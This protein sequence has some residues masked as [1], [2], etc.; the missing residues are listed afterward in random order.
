M[1]GI[2]NSHLYL[3]DIKKRSNIHAPACLFGIAHLI[4][5]ANPFKRLEDIILGFDS[6]MNGEDFVFHLYLIDR[7]N[8]YRQDQ[9]YQV[10]DQVIHNTLPMLSIHQASIK[11]NNRFVVVTREQDAA[12]LTSFN[13]DPIIIH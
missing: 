5:I 1:D 10:H 12:R 11:A 6:I 3:S 2:K 7:A 13:R 4:F 9:H 8:G